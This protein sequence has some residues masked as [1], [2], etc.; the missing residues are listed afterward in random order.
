MNPGIAEVKAK[1]LT[2]R[3]EKAGF[4]VQ[5]HPARPTDRGHAAFHHKRDRITDAHIPAQTRQAP[6]VESNRGSQVS[7]EPLASSPGIR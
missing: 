7:E 2:P 5:T 3:A 4:R 6:R 1:N